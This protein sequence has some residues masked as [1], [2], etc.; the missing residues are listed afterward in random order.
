MEE[1]RSKRLVT[2]CVLRWPQFVSIKQEHISRLYLHRMVDRRKTGDC[3]EF[4]GFVKTRDGRE[5]TDHFK[6]LNGS[7][8]KKGDE[9]NA[10][11]KQEFFTAFPRLRLHII[12]FR[13]RAPPSPVHY[14]PSAPFLE[15]VE[16]DIKSG[17]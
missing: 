2:A 6:S 13:V 11:K 12:P 15:Q 4:W 16:P 8:L 17:E 14:R 1:Y 5:Y 9:E 3:I 7:S 10:M